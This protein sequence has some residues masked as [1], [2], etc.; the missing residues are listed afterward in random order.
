M[1]LHDNSKLFKEVIAAV[2]AEYNYEDFQIEK[3]YYVSLLIKK[4]SL[5]P[6]IGPSVSPIVPT[7][8]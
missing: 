1:K 5:A 8:K 2:S 3:D 6:R 7:G 4:S